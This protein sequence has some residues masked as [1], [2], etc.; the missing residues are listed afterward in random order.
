MDYNSDKAK[1]EYQLL[2]AGYE[3]APASYTLDRSGVNLFLEAVE[4]TSRLYQA[5][6][7]VPPMAV[8]AYAMASLA[9][10]ISLPPGT[11]HV[12]Q[13]L[14]FLEVA[15]VGDTISCQAKVMKKQE[16]GKLHLMIIGLDVLNQDQKKVIS[17]KT[18]FVLPV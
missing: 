14:E 3:F 1:I 7:L 13:E 10:S 15:K 11:I 5:T 16:R 2:E 6:D 9:E 18:S 4:E 17:G 12:S 8:A